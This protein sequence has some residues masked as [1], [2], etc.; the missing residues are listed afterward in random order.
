MPGS[1]LST[2]SSFSSASLLPSATI[3]MP[4]WSEWPIPTPPPW[5]TDTQVAPLDAFSRAFK[6]GQSAIASLPSRLP[7]DVVA[8][9][10]DDRATRFE[11]EHRAHVFG[12]CAH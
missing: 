10:E 5:C 8:V 1:Q 12:H 3:T 9:V 6:M 2:R 7:S 4:A 11:R